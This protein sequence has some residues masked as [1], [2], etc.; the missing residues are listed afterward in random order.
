MRLVESS[1]L[2]V[3]KD[4]KC[5]LISQFFAYHAQSVQAHLDKTWERSPNKVRLVYTLSNTGPAS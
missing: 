4:A 3:T 5:V 1:E 2:C